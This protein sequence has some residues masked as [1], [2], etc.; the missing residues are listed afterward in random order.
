MLYLFKTALRPVL[1][2]N[3]S[4]DKWN[5]S[6]KTHEITSFRFSLLVYLFTS[7]NALYF[8]SRALFD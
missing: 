8:M 7:P 1:Q 6:D 5:N 2:G 3:M 4:T